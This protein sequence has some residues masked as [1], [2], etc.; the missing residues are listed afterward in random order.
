MLPK[1]K[2][3]GEGR[4]ILGQT[5]PRVKQE[6]AKIQDACGHDDAVFG[7]GAGHGRSELEAGEVVTICNHLPL[8]LGRQTEREVLGK[9][10]DIIV[11]TTVG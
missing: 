1:I 3:P 8:L 4:Q 11:R 2:Q 5:R 6:A 10:V 9:S 7:E